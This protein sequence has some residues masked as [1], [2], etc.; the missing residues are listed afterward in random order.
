MQWKAQERLQARIR[1]VWERD[2]LNEQDFQIKMFKYNSSQNA[3]R[4]ANPS[5]NN[6]ECGSLGE[7]QGNPRTV[8]I[9]PML[10]KGRWVKLGIFQLKQSK[11][12]D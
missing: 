8:I 7:V 11:K 3:V 5:Q 2:Y 12:P 4:T 10:A 6:E 1:K 9:V